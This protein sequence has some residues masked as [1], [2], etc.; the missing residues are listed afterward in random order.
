MSMS[1]RFWLYWAAA[2]TSYVGDGVRFAALPLLAASLS[3][4]PAAVAAVATAAGLPWL[5]FGLLAGVV[6]DRWPRLRLMAL[7]QLARAVVGLV[8]VLSIGAGQ[9]TIPRL[10][11]LVLLLT[12][13]EVFYDVAFHAALPS[14]VDRSD[15]QRANGRLITAEVVTFEFAGPALGGLLFAAAAAAPF[16]VDGATFAVSFLLLAMVARGVGGQPPATGA[17]RP[18]VRRELTE[19]MRW[20][21]RQRLVRGLTLL[22]VAVNLATGGFYA[23][24]VLFVRDDLGVGPAGFG[25]LLAVSAAGSVLG[26]VLSSRLTS[27]GRRRAVVLLTGPLTAACFVVVAASPSVVPVAAAMIVFGF[28]VTLANVVMVSLRQLATPDALLGRVTAVHRFLCWGAIPAGA[29]LA[30]LVGEIWGVRAAIACCGITLA[31]IGIAAGRPLL[32]LRSADFDPAPAR[33]A[34]EPRQQEQ[35][36]G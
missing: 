27:P 12:T 33:R 14:V 10:V 35:T 18:S 34:A 11:V 4:A 13:C 29:A 31:V 32:R 20:F 3:S 24:L 9:L 36:A 8:I 26:G 6:V 28:V 1:R 5:L 7:M 25:V 17:P 2:S 21:W 22:G 19:G 23:L 16:A 30:G 15:L